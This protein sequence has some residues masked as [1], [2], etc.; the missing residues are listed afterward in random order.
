MAGI[1][2]N[3]RHPTEADRRALRE[4]AS[5]VDAE[6]IIRMLGQIVC[7]DHPD[8]HVGQQYRRN[9]FAVAVDLCEDQDWLL[10]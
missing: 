4:M 3:T 9:L 7:H 1:E 10:R 8:L 5:R 2:R 6:E